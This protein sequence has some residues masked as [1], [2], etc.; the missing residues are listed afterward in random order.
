MIA[1]DNQVSSLVLAVEMGL[2]LTILFLLNVG[3]LVPAYDLTENSPIVFL[4]LL[5]NISFPHKFLVWKTP[6]LPPS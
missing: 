1:T 5:K 2:V 4:F 6:P 3:L